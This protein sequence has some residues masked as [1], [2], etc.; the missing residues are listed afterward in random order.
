[1]SQER[2]SN[3][4]YEGVMS[5][6]EFLEYSRYLL[7]ASLDDEDSWIFTGWGSAPLFVSTRPGFEGFTM[8]ETDDDFNAAGFTEIADFDVDV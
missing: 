2:G 1:M 5:Q 8:D 6:A 7:G 3:L 4:I